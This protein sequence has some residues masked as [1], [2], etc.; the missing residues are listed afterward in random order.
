MS[1]CLAYITFKDQ[2]EAKRIGEELITGKLVACFN[3]FPSVTSLYLWKGALQSESEVVA[4]AKLK[5]ENFE[6]LVRRVEE[7]HSY[8]TP[9]ILKLPVKGGSKPFLDWIEKSS[10]S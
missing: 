1:V 5:E 3:L 4:L 10:S 9:C 7:L 2:Q 6:K 8:E